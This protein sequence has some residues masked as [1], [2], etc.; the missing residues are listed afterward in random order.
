MISFVPEPV[1]TLHRIPGNIPG[2][3]YLT[4]A[5]NNI[6][7]VPLQQCLPVRVLGYHHPLLLLQPFNSHEG[8]L[9][10]QVIPEVT[11]DKGSGDPLTW[12]RIYRLLHTVTEG[13]AW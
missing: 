6:I 9:Q 10:H 4:L 12:S 11:G 8:V 5:Q 2:Q 1:Q 3:S 7:P 13:I